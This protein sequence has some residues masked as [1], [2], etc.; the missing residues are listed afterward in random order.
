MRALGIVGVTVGSGFLGVCIGAWYGDRH[1][2]GAFDF[3]PLLYGM[4][5]MIVGGLVGVV[6]SSVALAKG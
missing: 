6:G 1:S 5:G 3:D 2:T 4:L